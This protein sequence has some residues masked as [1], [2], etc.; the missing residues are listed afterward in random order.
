M[1]KLFVLL[2]LALLPLLA[3]VAQTSEAAPA[4]SVALSWTASSTACVSP[5]TSITY[6]VFRGTTPG[7]ENMTTPIATGIAGTTYSDTAVTLG[8]TYYYVVEAVEA[9]TG[10]PLYSVPSNEAS[11]TFPPAPLPPASLVGTPN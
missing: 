4:H 10:S 7:G 3:M 2:A 9:W 6:D 1:R 8:N 11:A 5:C